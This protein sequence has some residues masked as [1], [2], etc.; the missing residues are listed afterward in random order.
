MTVEELIWF[1]KDFDPNTEV[2]LAQ[3]PNWPLQYEIS[4]ITLY[5]DD[6]NEYVYITE[7]EQIGYISKEVF[8]R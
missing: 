8:Y 2:R 5:E 6:G 7:G 1:L 3:Q 4:N